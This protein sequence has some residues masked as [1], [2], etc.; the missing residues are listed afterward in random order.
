[1]NWIGQIA[2]QAQRRIQ[3]WRLGRAQAR[4]W[5]AAQAERWAREMT[6]G[7]REL[8]AAVAA[9]KRDLNAHWTRQPGQA[10]EPAVGQGAQP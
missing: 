5:Q 3:L 2:R 7:W 1:M 9:L 10:A 8:E 4:V 6:H